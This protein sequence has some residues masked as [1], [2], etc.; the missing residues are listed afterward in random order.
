VTACNTI[1][2]EIFLFICTHF[3]DP[4]SNPDYTPLNNQSVNN[5]FEK[6]WKETVTAPFNIYAGIFPEELMKN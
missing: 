2:N 5:E 3:N 6:T 1:K 4:T